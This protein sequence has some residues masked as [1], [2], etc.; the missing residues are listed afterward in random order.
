MPTLVI[1]LS[2]LL[3]ATAT[4]IPLTLGSGG[5]YYVHTVVDSDV[6]SDML[7]DTGSKYVVLSG[8]TFNTIKQTHTMTVVDTIRGVTANGSVNTYTVYLLESL[9]VS[10]CVLHNVR[11]VLISNSDKDILGISALE[12]LSPFSVNLRESSLTVSC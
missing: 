7:L 6:D 10:G 12:S 1:L 8:K 5:G 11:A 9:A 3:S 2:L 4:A